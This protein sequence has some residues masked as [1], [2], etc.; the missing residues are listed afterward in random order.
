MSVSVLPLK[1]HHQLPHALM[2]NF[3]YLVFDPEAREAL[4]IDPAWEMEKIEAAL[5]QHQLTLTTILVTHGHND[6][7][8]LVKPLVEKYGCEVRMSEVEAADFSFACDNL[9]TIR[10]EEPFQ[11]AG[12]TVTPLHTPGHTRGCICYLIGGNLFTGDTLF[13]EGCG[14]CFGG[15]SSP[16]ELFRSL[17]RLK[18]TL[19]PATRIFP[20]HSYGAVP[21]Q[22]FS[23]VLRHNIYIQFQEENGFIAFRMRSGQTGFFDFK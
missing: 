20:A 21:G 7:V 16:Q 6:H 18:Q 19:L 17:Q 11:A 14:M 8:H 10:G 12:L 15:N 5:D 9:R 1:M 22:A 2:K 13:I 4:I 23:F 3:T